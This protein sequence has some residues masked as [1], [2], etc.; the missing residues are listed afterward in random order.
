[1]RA[2]VT[3]PREFDASDHGIAQLLDES[4]RGAVSAAFAT[5][6]RIAAT[7]LAEATDRGVRVPADLAGVGYD[8]TELATLVRPRLTSVDQ[9]RSGMGADATS[10]ALAMLRGEEPQRHVAEPTLVVRASSGAG[11]G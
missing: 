6:D 2:R 10:Q 7:I 5:N 3:D 1:Y 9:P 4:K 8:H 11:S